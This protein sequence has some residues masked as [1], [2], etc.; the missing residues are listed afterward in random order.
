M[1]RIKHYIEYLAVIFIRWLVCSISLKTALKIGDFVGDFIFYALKIRK[2][3]AIENL[4][5]AFPEKIEKEL[6]EITHRLYRNVGRLIV[7]FARLPLLDEKVINE[8][9]DIEG[10]DVLKTALFEGK[11][12]IIMSGHF[13]NWELMAGALAKKGYPINVVELEQSNKKVNEIMRQHRKSTGIRLI[14]TQRALRESLRALKSNQFVAILADQSG[15][16][17]GLYIKYFGIDSSTPKGPA[18]IALKTGS[19]II[20]GYDIRK[21][22][23]KHY[24]KFERLD[25]S[26]LTGNEEED[27]KIITQRHTSMLEQYVRKYPDHWFWMHRRW[28]HTP[29]KNEKY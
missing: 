29:G 15:G 22:N 11:G 12:A 1:K 18:V 23:F 21:D 5:R 4:K 9:C 13:G 27:I 8:I 7:E 10:E 6:I 14:P 17:D 26:G 19:P 3:V 24:I 28:K 2:K 16:K 20:V 25:L